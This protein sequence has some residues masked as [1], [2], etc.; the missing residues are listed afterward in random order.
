MAFEFAHPQNGP[1]QLHNPWEK[2]T[3]RN[4]KMHVAEDGSRLIGEDHSRLPTASTTNVDVID[5]TASM[6][7]IEQF[8][9]HR[10]G[11]LEISIPQRRQ[12]LR[13]YLEAA[14]AD[15][16]SHPNRFVENDIGHFSKTWDIALLDDRQNHQNCARPYKNPCSKC[17]IL[18]KSL[19]I[20]ELFLRLKENVRC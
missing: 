8:M 6:T 17:Q 7:V 9:T 11:P 2:F 16:A 15:A 14:A 3:R 1:T 19:S 18:S 20:P 13:D 12:L 10:T 5:S 4:E